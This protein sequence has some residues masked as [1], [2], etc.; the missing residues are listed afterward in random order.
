MGKIR[1]YRGFA[2]AQEAINVLK[3][4]TAGGVILSDDDWESLYRDNYTQAIP[5][6][7]CGAGGV[8][9]VVQV[10]GDPPLD[11]KGV[12]EYTTNMGTA[13]YFGTLCVIEAEADKNTMLSHTA[14]SEC[15]VF[16]KTNQKIEI[17]GFIFGYFYQ[18]NVYDRKALQ[19]LIIPEEW[20]KLKSHIDI[21]YKRELN[22]DEL[23][24]LSYFVNTLK[25][26]NLIR[27][28]LHKGEI[29]FYC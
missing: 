26:S 13:L 23:A 11:R 28:E 1:I 5:Q 4:Q 19:D 10:N 24:I 22:K 8:E 15:S 6:Q 17:L 2:N 18:Y 25:N 3:E 20:E 27:D 9:G 16:F 7:M 29:N 12:I 14:N 21:P